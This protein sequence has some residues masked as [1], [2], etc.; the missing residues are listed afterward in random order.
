MAAMFVLIFT[1]GAI[2]LNNYSKQ[3]NI[4]TLQQQTAE[5]KKAVNQILLD[6]ANEEQIVDY[7]IAEAN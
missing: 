3:N 4:N 5:Y 1:V 7:I 6:E 2:F